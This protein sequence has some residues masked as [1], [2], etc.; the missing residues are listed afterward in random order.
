MIQNTTKNT[1]QRKHNFSAKFLL[2]EKSILI[3]RLYLKKTPHLRIKNA[4]CPTCPSKMTLHLIMPT[5]IPA[6]LV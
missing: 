6:P 5:Y 3:I 4:V 2:V 1:N